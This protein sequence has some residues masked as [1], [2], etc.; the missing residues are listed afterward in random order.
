MHYDIQLR[1]R[2]SSTIVKN[3]LRPQ[4]AYV[5]PLL[6]NKLYHKR[7]GLTGFFDATFM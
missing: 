7:S 4:D 1:I 2:S 5:L 6:F 3:Y